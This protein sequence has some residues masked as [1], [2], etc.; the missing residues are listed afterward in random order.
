MS[1][2]ITSGGSPVV[3][4]KPFID[5]VTIAVVA[6]TEV[7]FVFPQTTKV[8]T[9]INTGDTIVEYSYVSGGNFFP[10]RPGE[11]YNRTGMRLA[12]AITYYFK[13]VKAGQLIMIDYWT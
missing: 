7:S 2:V 4:S 5:S 13:S 1:N 3:I 12:S 11:V 6:P 8:I 10:L 9:F